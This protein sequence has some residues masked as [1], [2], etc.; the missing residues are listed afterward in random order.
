[1]AWRTAGRVGWGGHRGQ[2]NGLG[3]HGGRWRRQLRIASPKCPTSAPRIAPELSS[4][5]FFFQRIAVDRDG[6][7]ADILKFL[8]LGLADHKSLIYRHIAIDHLW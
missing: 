2:G 3:L 7:I 6:C 1:M 4:Q 5:E 8:F